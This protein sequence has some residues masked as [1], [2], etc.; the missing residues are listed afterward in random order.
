MIEVQ[1]QAVSSAASLAPSPDPPA[2]PS[3]RSR[4]SLKGKKKGLGC[5]DKHSATEPAIA[6]NWSD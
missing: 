2:H 5:Q 6:P 1:L 3:T 4:W